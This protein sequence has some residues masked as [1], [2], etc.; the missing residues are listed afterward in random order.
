[1]VVETAEGLARGGKRE[2]RSSSE[3]WK[4]FRWDEEDDGGTARRRWRFFGGG[5]QIKLLD[6]DDG[7]VGGVW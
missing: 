3:T 7:D 5:G 4:N 6:N 1:M 2:A